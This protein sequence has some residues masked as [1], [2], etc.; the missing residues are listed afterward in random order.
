[1]T[2]SANVKMSKEPCPIAGEHP[3]V[4]RPASRPPSS[5]P[6]SGLPPAL[7]LVARHI[8]ERLGEAAVM[9]MRIR[10]DAG[11]LAHII[12]SDRHFPPRALVDLSTVLHIDPSRLRRYARVTEAITPGEFDDLMDLRDTVGRTLTWSHIEQLALIR[13]AHGRRRT[14][15]EIVCHGLSVRQLAVHLR[16]LGRRSP[17]LPS[18]GTAG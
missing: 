11:H 17:N 12:R 5:P 2:A 3:L 6:Q 18:S 14:A 4:S 15:E 10:Y 7:G 16:V 13:Q 1:V 8:V 9:D